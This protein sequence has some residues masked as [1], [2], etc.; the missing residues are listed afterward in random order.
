M[1][2]NKFNTTKKD[3]LLEAVQTAMQDGQIRRQAEAFVNEEFGVYSR[4][5]VVR[6][7]LAAYDAR[8]EEAYKHMKEGKPLDPVGREDKDI[9]ND[10]DH[11]KTDKYLLHRRAVRSKVIKMKEGTVVSQSGS[12]TKLS[13][14]G[15]PGEYHEKNTPEERNTKATFD[16]MRQMKEGSMYSGKNPFDPKDPSVQG[17]GD[18][19]STPAPKPMARKAPNDPSVQ[20]SGD[21]T[22]NGRPARVQENRLDEVSRKTLVSYIRKAAKSKATPE[23]ISKRAKGMEMAAKRMEEEQI[24]ELKQ[25]TIRSY[26]DKAHARATAAR[27]AGLKKDFTEK[28]GK[29]AETARQEFHK[30]VKGLGLAGKKLSEEESDSFKSAQVRESNKLALGKSVN[31]QGPFDLGTPDPSMRIRGGDPKSFA[32]RVAGIVKNAASRAGQYSPLARDVGRGAGRGS[33]VS[34]AIIGANEL[35]RAATQTKTGQQIGKAIGDYVPGAKAAADA[36]KPAQNYLR[37]LTGFGTYNRNA[38]PTPKAAPAATPS[39][40]SV[41]LN[42]A[43]T[44]KPTTFQRTPT[45]GPDTAK[46]T[47]NKPAAPAPAPTKAAPSAA[48]RG[49]Q[50]SIADIAKMNKIRDVN[51]IYA[52]KT[53]DVGGGDKYTIQK[54]DTLTKIAK[55]FMGSGK[56]AAEP[57]AAPAQPAPAT[58][59]PGPEPEMKGRM[60]PPSESGVKTTTSTT[61]TTS[62]GSEKEIRSAGPVGSM[63]SKDFAK[64]PPVKEEDEK[65]SLKE[66]VTV[67]GNK[68]RIV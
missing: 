61:P 57:T 60:I 33:I 41:A 25:S 31:E 36:L 67:G 56:P 17:S 34:G 5:A 24:D 64:H 55:G 37:N 62:F 45:V 50:G 6:E 65:K 68:Y 19:T 43:T 53:I 7:Q 48:G 29:K 40:P 21:V 39:K 59:T 20:G 49:L 51:K 4:Q 3:P 8:L 13:D 15:H 12:G 26:V 58:Q 2:S 52:G 66:S 14:E 18:V 35:G 28:K 23:N 27:S 47:S 9:D 10:G 54:G 16:R 11:D 32:S 46:F 44:G 42:P 30:R 63:S 1:F 22:M 38:P